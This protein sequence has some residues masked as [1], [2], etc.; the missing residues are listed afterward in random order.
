MTVLLTFSIFLVLSWGVSLIAIGRPVR[1]VFL[2]REHC[3]QVKGYAAVAVI[4]SHVAAYLGIN[5]VEFPSGVGVS[6]FI[7][8]SGFGIEASFQKNKLEGF[9]KKRLERV[10]LPFALCD[11]LAII[12]TKRNVSIY[13]AVLNFTLIKEIFPFLWFFRFI[14][15]CYLLF[16]VVSYIYLYNDK[17]RRN[18][19]LFVLFFCWFVLKSTLWV[20]ETPFLEPRQIVCF[21]LG[22]ILAQNIGKVREYINHHPK[23]LAGL[24]MGLTFGGVLIYFAIHIPK[25]G[26]LNSSDLLYNFLASFTCM[27]CALGLLWIIYA[28]RF[29]QTTA[30]KYIGLISYEIYIAQRYFVNRFSVEGSIIGLIRFVFCTSFCAI[31][32]YLLSKQMIRKEKWHFR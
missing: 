14:F 3:E 26:E 7:I 23:K 12:V 22:I 24:T 21:L 18:I 10:Y 13:R 9:W 20:D 5:G 15:V 17:L 11:L 6:I 2:D 30:M 27:P 31:S 8:L 1:F 19:W 4:W 29:L 16:Y 32:L 25:F 28:C